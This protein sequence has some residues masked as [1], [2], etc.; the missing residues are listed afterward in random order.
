MNKFK[1]L[2]EDLMLLRKE[3]NVLKRKE[4]SKYIAYKCSFE[5]WEKIADETI[6]LS[7]KVCRIQDQMIAILEEGSSH[8]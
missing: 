2:E 7:K 6:A 3:Q 1:E 4:R 5:R 8:E